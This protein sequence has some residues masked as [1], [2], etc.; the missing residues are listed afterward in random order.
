[1]SAIGGEVGLAVDGRQ[2]GP[3]LR[4]STGGAES[5]RV[6]EGT[7][8]VARGASAWAMTRVD[9]ENGLTCGVPIADLAVNWDERAARSSSSLIIEDRTDEVGKDLCTPT[10]LPKS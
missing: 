10:G 5:V 3:L 2:P 8:P 4:T 7:G 1:M 9:G 6:G